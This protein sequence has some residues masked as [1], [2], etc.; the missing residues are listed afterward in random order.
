MELHDLAKMA[1]LLGLRTAEEVREWA[2]ARSPDTVLVAAETAAQRLGS[3]PDWRDIAAE[4][5]ENPEEQI[6]IASAM[7]VSD[8]TAGAEWLERQARYRGRVEGARRVADIARRLADELDGEWRVSE[9]GSSAYVE[10]YDDDGGLRV[11]RI[12]DHAPSFRATYDFGVKV[13]TG[14][15]IS[16]KRPWTTSDVTVE[17]DEPSDEAA[18]MIARFLRRV[19]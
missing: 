19:R 13:E 11:A 8:L 6:R 7:A 1:I 9:S 17:A 16:E 5:T 15:E 10:W 18:H 4:E 14:S 12:S 2:S 3:H